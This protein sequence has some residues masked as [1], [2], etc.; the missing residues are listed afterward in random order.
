MEISRGSVE[1]SRGVEVLCV[2]VM[3]SWSL[4]FD[5]VL[6]SSSDVTF[7]GDRGSPCTGVVDP[8]DR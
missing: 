8:R 5:I 6:S 3:T 2:S 7:L 1:I 4:F